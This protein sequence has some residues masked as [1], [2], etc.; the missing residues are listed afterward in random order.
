[1]LLQEQSFDIIGIPNDG[2]GLARKAFELCCWWKYG[3]ADPWNVSV[4]ALILDLSVVYE[5]IFY[6]REVVLLTYGSA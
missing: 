5:L 3:A 2:I 1:M 6:S 4:N